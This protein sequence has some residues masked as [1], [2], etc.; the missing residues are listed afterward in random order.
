[1]SIIL[2]E[3]TQNVLSEVLRVVDETRRRLEET[4]ESKAGVTSTDEA[5]TGVDNTTEAATTNNQ[6]GVTKEVDITGASTTEDEEEVEGTLLTVEGSDVSD[7]STKPTEVWTLRPN[8]STG[9]A[10][11]EIGWRLQAALQFI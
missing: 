9:V 6:S 1:M 11:V 8:W 3:E 5:V 10:C 4:K 2:E 7:G